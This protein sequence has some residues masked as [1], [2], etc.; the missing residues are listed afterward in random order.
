MLN[1][2]KII[3]LAASVSL[4]LSSCTIRTRVIQVPLSVPVMLLQD[5]D[6]VRIAVPDKDGKLV[7]VVGRLFSGQWV[8]SITEEELNK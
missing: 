2:A 1:L 7:P 4:S 5:V 8:T 3:L 6:N